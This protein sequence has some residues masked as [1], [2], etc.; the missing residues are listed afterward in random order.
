MLPD[1]NNPSSISEA[2]KDPPGCMPPAAPD[3]SDSKGPG[4][5]VGKTSATA[6]AIQAALLHYR[7][8]KYFM[9]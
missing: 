7:S 1:T 6:R 2:E 4:K 8:L 3:N 9:N 5:F